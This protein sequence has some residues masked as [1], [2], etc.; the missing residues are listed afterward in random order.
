MALC[1]FLIFICQFQPSLPTRG[2]TKLLWIALLTSIIST[3]S[4]HAGRDVADF[5]QYMDNYEIST[6][7][8]HAG[9][10]RLLFAS[11]AAIRGFQP[12]L[13]TRGETFVQRLLMALIS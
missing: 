12:T 5:G 4:P 6:H 10:D 1:I 2:E 8:P 11:P 3:H 9:R 13:P 7:S